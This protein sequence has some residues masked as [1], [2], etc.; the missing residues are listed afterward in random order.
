MKLITN[1]NSIFFFLAIGVVS[2]A[3]FGFSNFPEGDDDYADDNHLRYDDYTYNDSIKSVLLYNSR[4][5]LTYPII[6]INGDEIIKLS[7]DDLSRKYINYYYT[8][9]HCNANWT[10]SDLESNEYINGFNENQIIDYKY[11]FNTDLYYTHYNTEF[12]NENLSFTKSGNYI[13]KVYPEDKPNEPILTKRFMVYNPQVT[14]TM[15]IHRATNV[16][17]QFFRQEVDFNINH[18]NYDIPNPFKDLNVVIMQNHR[19]D[20][21]ITGLKPR[22]VKDNELDYNYDGKNVFDG[23][24]EYRNFDL[25]SIKYQ[26]INI[27]KIQYEPEDKLVH[28]YILDDN[29]R[30]YKQYS[31]MPDL[32]GNFLIK[33]N[34]GND[35]EIEA[36]YVKVHFSL[37][38]NFPITDG[39]L[40]IFGKLSDWKF[41]DEFKMDYDSAHVRYTK[42][43]LLKQGYYDYMYCVVKDGAKN[44]GDL[45]I[46]EGSFYETKNEYSILVYYRSPK[47]NYDR[48]IGYNTETSGS[49]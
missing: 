35:S 44:K 42:E 19:W 23:D 14:I 29:V 37:P 26:T 31:S 45:S 20:N 48:L 8:I 41:K 5:A 36:D 46:I 17:D 33:R 11:A 18:E 2:C 40:Y 32:N 10:P 6:P 12:P 25:K 13:I 16:D 38:Y 49:K 22:F 15:N 9:I 27:K 21:A 34:E 3:C 24:N 47:D 43:I 39:N 7:F 4:S 30:S 1:N 28:A